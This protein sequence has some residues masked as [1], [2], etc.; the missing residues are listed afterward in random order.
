MIRAVICDVYGTLLEVGPPPPDAEDRWVRLWRESVEASNPPRLDELDTAVRRLVPAHHA[1]G[2]ARGLVQPEIDW[3]ALAAQAFPAL[4]RLPPA[5]RASF[6]FEHARLTRSTRLAAGAADCLRSWQRAGLVLGIASNAQACTRL[7]LAAD[8]AAAGLDPSVF[9]EDACFF[10]Y[11]HGVAKPDPRVFHTLSDRLAR[12]GISPA[13]TLMVGDRLDTDVE[14]AATA[15][16][17]AWQLTLGPGPR[18]GTWP[19]LQAWLG[20]A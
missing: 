6:F 5:R 10:S 7:E 19:A 9:A 12:H 17:S 13:E 18:A 8:L 3:P 1:A 14:P 4:H 2:R 20:L 16:W 11:E 15:G